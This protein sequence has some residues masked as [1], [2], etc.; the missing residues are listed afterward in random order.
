MDAVSAAIFDC[1]Q[2]KTR[3]GSTF[4]FIIEKKQKNGAMNHDVHPKKINRATTVE[5][6]AVVVA[7]FTLLNLLYGG[8]YDAMTDFGIKGLNIILQLLRIQPPVVRQI[9]TNPILDPL[10]TA[11]TRT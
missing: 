1:G 3:V 6:V 11:I 2:A 5:A 10:I 4:T 9:Y 7:A 8:E